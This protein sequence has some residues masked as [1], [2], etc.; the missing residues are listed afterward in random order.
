[1][2]YDWIRQANISPHTLNSTCEINCGTCGDYC[3]GTL[4]KTPCDGMV[5]MLT[6]ETKE[7]NDEL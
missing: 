7:K 2:L 6:I 4:I 5:K 3:D 1:M